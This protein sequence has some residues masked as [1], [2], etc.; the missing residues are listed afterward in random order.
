MDSLGQKLKKE[1]VLRGVS[2]GDVA[3][4]TRIQQK[5]LEALEDN[6]FDVLPAPVF[7]TGFLRVYA[8]YLGMDADAIISEYE[9]SRQTTQPA[10]EN[11]HKAN[12]EPDGK[13]LPLIAGAA[14]AVV[15]LI[16]VV[17]YNFRP[18]IKHE[19]KPVEE[20]LLSP[21]PAPPQPE[22]ASTDMPGAQAGKMQEAAPSAIALM[23]EATNASA[24]RGFKGE[25]KPE[26]KP[27]P[28]KQQEKPASAP[29]APQPKPK[30][31]EKADTAKANAPH[32]MSLTAT[33]EDV[34]IYVVIDGDDVRDMYIRAG[35]TVYLHGNKS[36][37]LTTGNAKFLKLKLGD[38][39]VNIPGADA[40]KVIRNW[41]IPLGTERDAG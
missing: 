5:F 6:N 10:A 33:T 19:T 26:Q 37:L 17:S 16:A 32:N 40:N 34:W 36:F 41:P 22:Q 24:D 35:Q 27:E 13:N 25:P 30:T 7:I 38:R 31:A 11:A 4:S 20:E 28:V 29:V 1:R 14:I 2:I 9:T 21:P 23:R 12:A 18:V 3:Q 8:N 15:I 39:G